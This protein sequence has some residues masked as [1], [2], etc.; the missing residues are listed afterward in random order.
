MCLR[1][2]CVEFTRILPC[3]LHGLPASDTETTSTPTTPK[4]LIPAEAKFYPPIEA[5]AAVA[6]L[7]AEEPTAVTTHAVDK[8]A[9]M[10]GSKRNAFANCEN[11]VKVRRKL[12]KSEEKYAQAT[13]RLDWLSI[14]P[15][16]VLRDEEDEE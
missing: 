6:A 15:S 8:T 13:K 10:A 7:E 11:K 16:R 14:S 5:L 2:R 4:N 1:E 12:L 9:P 3:V